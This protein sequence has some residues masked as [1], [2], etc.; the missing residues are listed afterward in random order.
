M[1]YCFK[2]KVRYKAYARFCLMSVSFL[3]DL[4]I[5]HLLRLECLTYVLHVLL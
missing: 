3:L 2:D 5:A 1:F 4:A